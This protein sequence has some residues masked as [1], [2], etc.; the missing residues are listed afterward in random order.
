MFIIGMVLLIASVVAQLIIQ[1]TTSCTN[2]QAGST[3]S[4]ICGGT[5]AYANLTW[6]GLGVTLGVRLSSSFWGAF[7]CSFC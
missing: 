1:A 6:A 3:Q 7:F 5:G 4:L 2:A